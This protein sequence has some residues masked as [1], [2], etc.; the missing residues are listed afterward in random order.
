MNKISGNYKL[1]ALALVLLWVA[2]VNA[3]S[4]E[5]TLEWLPKTKTFS[6]IDGKTIIQPTFTKAAHSDQLGLLPVYN[7]LIPLSVSGDVSVQLVNPVYAVSGQLDNASLAFIKDAVEPKADLSLLRKQPYASISFLPFRKNTSTGVV[8]RL[9]SFTLRVTVTAK[10][11]HRGLNAYAT[12]SRLASG[13]F[14]KVAVTAEGMY[15]IDYNFVKNILKVEPSTFNL[16]TLAIY[17]NGGGMVPE[18]N[19]VARPDDLIENPTMVVDNNGNNKMDDG[20]YLL[21]YGQM[22]D[23]WKFNAAT[24]V[25]THEK[26]LYTDQTYYFLTTDAGTGKRVTPAYSDASP[27]KIITDFDEHAYH[28]SD[29]VNLIA[30]GKRWLG[31][32]MSSFDNSKDFSLNF[33]NLITSVPVKFT[34]RVAAATTYGSNTAVRINGQNVFTHSVGGIP[35]S[36]YPQASIPGQLTANYNANSSQININYTFNP[37]ADPAGTA[38]C[39]VDWFELFLKRSLTM[40]GDVM[41]FRSVASIGAGS[42][43]NFQLN[44]A[45]GNTKVWNITSLDNIQ[46]MQG[47]LNGSQFSFSTTTTELKEFIAFNMGA[48]FANPTLVGKIENQN[49]HALGQADMLIITADEFVNP[50][51]ELAQFHRTM[52]NLSV[53]VVKISQIFNE[54]GS[55]K[56]DISAM[57]DFVKMFYDRANGDTALMPRYLLLMGDGTYDP[58]NRVP[59]NNNFVS[60]YQSIESDSPTESYTSDDFFGLLDSNEGGDITGG[61]QLLDIGIGRLTAG[62]ETDAWDMVNKIK[63]YKRPVPD[64]TCVQINNNASWRNIIS[65]IGDDEDYNVH[66][67]SSDILA[68]LTRQRQPAYNYEKIYLD[69]YKQT[70]TPAG[71]RYPDVNT[72]ILN[73]LNAGCLIMNWVGHGGETNWAHERIFNMAD[74]VPLENKEKLPMF[75]TA[76]CDFS[77]FDLPTRT[78]GEWLVV[79]GKGGA[80]ASL[81]TVRLVYSSGNAALNDAA[82]DYMFDE[83]E[84]RYPRLGEIIMLTKNAT[85]SQGSNTRKFTL[86]GDPALTLNYP[87]YNVVT[88]AV[89]NNPVMSADTIKALEEVT[90]RGEVRDDNGNKMT[91][92]TGTVYPLVYDKISTVTTLKN[93]PGSNIVNFLQYKN[94]LFKGKA[95][96]TNGDF[97]FTFLVPKDIDYQYGKGRIS[98]YAD[99]SSYIDAHGYTNEIIIGGSAD[100]FRVDN[101][102][103]EMNIYMNDEK[104]VY[105]GT[106]NTDPMLLVKLMDQSGINTVGNGIG[107]DLT[108]IL[109]DNTQNR[110][111]LNDYYESALDN[112]KQGEVKYPYSKLKEGRHTLKVKAWDIHNN[113]SEE[114]TEFIVANNAKLAL[115][116]VYNYPNPFTTHTQFMFEHNRCCDD[117]SIS[118]QIFSVSGKLVKSIVQQVQSQGYRVDNIEWDG[119][120]DYGDAIGKGVYVYKLAVRDGE[121][122]TAHKY[123]KLVVL[124]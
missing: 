21:F 8:E 83:Y 70:P 12:T 24:Q 109:D 89:N 102:G 124:R 48:A 96:V 67:G 3:Q 56:P 15:K 38:A 18:L 62:S 35:S 100:S 52:D 80:I 37:N 106:T 88:T 1:S 30:T 107:H 91:S 43:S 95:S 79:N 19:S 57:R 104:F 42:V 51:N 110:V 114:F 32:K 49:L 115:S 73:R 44:N 122:N 45:G 105:G 11:Q 6:T 53:D 23:A 119:L 2:N 98:Y 9:E 82:F 111:V 55:G 103:P 14:Y 90:I 112:Y 4:Y 101:A 74:I 61:G 50:S 7:E 28:E 72:A 81:T 113:S 64:A 117:L 36:S 17:G 41:P 39:Y 26:N 75:I 60:T 59:N 78:A 54:F 121:G 63:N 71:D 92:F 66:L 20:D 108:A 86:L 85:V 65:F 87:R 29:E 84:G 13:N 16:N 31:D 99:N 120:D 25:F 22:P 34:S 69:A 93:D 33:P 10:P 76:T 40:A 123:E 58:K 94:I 97:S 46:E 47:T 5:R 118:V 27:N 77:R 68:E 116:H